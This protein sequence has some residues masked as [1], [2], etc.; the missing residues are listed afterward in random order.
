MPEA[1]T[2]L[3]ALSESQAREALFACCGSEQWVELMLAELPFASN[4]QLF[5]VA[6]TAWRGLGSAD[7]LQAFRHHPEIGM[8]A[9]TLAKRFAKTAA[10]SSAEQSSVAVA[11]EQTLNE[12]AD[13]NRRYK[14]RFGYIFIICATGKSARD[15]LAHLKRRMDNSPETELAIAA[16]E[17]AHIT[18]LR[19]ERLGT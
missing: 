11:D 6:D 13:L 12:L 18:R 7:Y 10:L 5:A 3:N 17:Q 16:G 8:D 1:F 2:R 19:M 4:E 9:A 14:A 15:M